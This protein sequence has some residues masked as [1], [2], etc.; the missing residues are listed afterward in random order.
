MMFKLIGKHT[1]TMRMMT[2]KMKF[3]SMAVL[4]VAAAALSSCE[5][6][7]LSNV[8]SGTYTTTVDM[9]E[10]NTKA[11]TSGGVKTFAAGERI[12]VIYMNTSGETKKAV[13]AALTAGDIQNSGKKAQFTVELEDP[14]NTAA[15]R[16]IYPASMAKATIATD[17]TMD[18]AGTI[19]F[20]KLCDQNGTLDNIDSLDL[21]VFEAA[22]WGGTE[23]PANQTLT[24]KLAIGKFSFKK[25]G[26]PINSDIKML[27]I[28]D[29]THS[30]YIQRPSASADPIFV[31]MMPVANQYFTFHAANAD[32]SNKY[33]Y[34]VSNKTLLANKWY[35][36][37]I[38]TT[39]LQTGATFGKFSIDGSNTV[40][41]SQG[42][43]K[44]ASGTWRF[45]T[46][47]YD[48]VGGTSQTT[49]NMDLFY[50][51]GSSKDYGATQDYNWGGESEYDAVN[52]GDNTITNA[53][54]S[55][56]T[57]SIDAWQY[58]FNTRST[59]TVNGT[60][61]ARFARGQVCGVNGVILFPNRYTHPTD[62][63][64]PVDINDD[65]NYIVWGT[66]NVYNSANWA[67]MEA[68]GA[69]FL[70]A[71]GYRYDGSDVYVVGDYGYYW[72]STADDEYNVWLAYFHVSNV[73]T[74]GNLGRYS[75]L[76][77]RLVCE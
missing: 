58:I 13:S 25:S 11:L 19:D 28:G 69:V 61:N 30:Y 50:W 1:K 9:A 7:T 17:A 36:L 26:S 38:S 15:I 77:V 27:Y 74:D 35:E 21:C 16:Y 33:E 68:A 54:G 37:E 8:V 63:A 49:S 64:L 65:N 18:D 76:S 51:G 14:D 57:P 29:G 66:H 53:S 42:N 12:A 60:A 67:K 62:V 41:F 52:W 22:S 75:G 39:K 24:N 40:H 3:F 20:T 23:L 2:N 5:K 10:N 44:Y 70:P 34:E 59:S 72:S 56:S 45:H 73:Y 6:E 43:L 71:A 55:W 32:G 46:H 47:Q 48:M 31:A 4:F